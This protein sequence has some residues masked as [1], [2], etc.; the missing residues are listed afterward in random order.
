[1]PQASPVVKAQESHLLAQGD[2]YIPASKTP[3]QAKKDAVVDQ[4]TL[5]SGVTAAETAS[6]KTC[7]ALNKVTE[8]AT[9]LK[10]TALAMNYI[11]KL[12]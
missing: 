12:L 7:V 11:G 8:Q 6:L 9:H 3:S 5:D 1:M 4:I 2:H 10:G